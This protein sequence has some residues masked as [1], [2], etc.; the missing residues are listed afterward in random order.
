MESVGGAAFIMRI[1]VTR[2]TN[3]IKY[4]DAIIPDA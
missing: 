4:S 3:A 1:V 2:V